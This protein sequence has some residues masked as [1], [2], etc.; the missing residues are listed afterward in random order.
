MGAAARPL[1]T[2][3]N[4]E[5]PRPPRRIRSRKLFER[6]LVRDAFKQS[7]VMLRPDIQWSNPV[8][9]VVEIGSL[10]TTAL[11]IDNLAPPLR[12]GEGVGG[13][14]LFSTIARKTT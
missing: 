7:F 14:G 4:P 6:E 2:V 9:F 12:F 10:L 3:E 13:W 1:R 5:Y 11:L 8:M